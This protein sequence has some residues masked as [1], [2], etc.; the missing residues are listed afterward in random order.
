MATLIISFILGFIAGAYFF[1]QVKKY[2]ES[3]D[4]PARTQSK[5]E[6]F[7]VETFDNKICY[8]KAY[9]KDDMLRCK[10]TVKNIEGNSL[11]VKDE[12]YRILLVDEEGIHLNHK[13]YS[14]EYT[15]FPVEFV[16][17]H[18]ILF[19]YEDIKHVNDEVL[20][21]KDLTGNWYICENCWL[22]LKEF[23]PMG[24]RIRKK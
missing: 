20:E 14:N 19:N 7:K 24:L 23:K 12:I 11:F 10:I 5:H 15:S 21:Y 1:S 16:N 4:I 2:L 6:I 3:Q 22:K 13:L 9:G 17:E 8:T 18:F